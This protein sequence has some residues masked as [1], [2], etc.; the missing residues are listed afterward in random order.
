MFVLKSAKHPN[1]FYVPSTADANVRVFDL[2]ADNTLTLVDVIYTGYPADNLTVDE[3]DNIYAACFANVPTLL[4]VF[5]DPYN[6]RT[7]T[8][9]LKIS[10]NQGEGRFYGKK[11]N[12]EKVFQDDGSGISGAT[13]ALWDQE[14]N[15]FWVAGKYR[16]YNTHVNIAICQEREEQ[17]C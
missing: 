7:P 14:N 2:Q 11:W 6:A 5:K 3:D 8:T 4:A 16:H 15:G 10:S 17:R 9:V 12:V 13:T 1:R